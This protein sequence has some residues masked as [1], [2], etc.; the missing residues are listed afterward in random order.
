MV[1]ILGVLDILDILD[2]LD[3]LGALLSSLTSDFNIRYSGNYNVI[4]P[5]HPC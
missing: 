4:S 1:D 5:P 3:V 2:I